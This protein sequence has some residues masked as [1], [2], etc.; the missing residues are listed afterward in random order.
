MK[1]ELIKEP[2]ELEIGVVYGVIDR[3]PK[4][5]NY[6]QQFMKIIKE[7]NKYYTV[8][9]DYN[10]VSKHNKLNYYVSKYHPSLEDVMKY[11]GEIYKLKGIE[12]F[13]NINIPENLGQ[14]IEE[15]FIEY[16]KY[17]LEEYRK[18]KGKYKKSRYIEPDELRELRSDELLSNIVDWSE[19]QVLLDIQ[20]I[21]NPFELRDKLNTIE[22]E[23][24]KL[25]RENQDIVL[26][27]DTLNIELNL[28]NDYDNCA[29]DEHIVTISS[30][31]FKKP[32]DKVLYMLAYKYVLSKHISLF[33]YYD[34]KAIQSYL[35][36]DLTKKGFLKAINP[37]ID[38]TC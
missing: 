38:K 18:L 27:K 29:I 19:T 30:I 15:K 25:L 36:G 34:C 10:Y 26:I 11:Y 21:D 33:Y 37:F 13:N 22:D 6:S 2:E 31:K 16:K 3:A 17:L 20:G 35:E 9:S 14:L 23:I 28:Y 8:T 32:D 4:E 7:E 24:D 1:Y 12:E 5:I